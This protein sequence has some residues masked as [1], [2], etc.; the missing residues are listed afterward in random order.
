MNNNETQQP[1]ECRCGREFISEQAFLIHLEKHSPE[2]DSVTRV[3][4]A[5]M[6]L[7]PNELPNEQR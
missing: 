4:H 2:F 7:L 6:S 5:A 1:F 3:E